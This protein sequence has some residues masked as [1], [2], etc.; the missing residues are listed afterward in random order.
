M[1][2]ENSYWVLRAESNELAVVHQC[3]RSG[4]CSF[5]ELVCSLVPR[6]ADMRREPLKD[7]YTTAG[8]KCQQTECDVVSAPNRTHRKCSRFWKHWSTK[9]NKYVLRTMPCETPRLTERG[10]LILP[11]GTVNVRSVT[12]A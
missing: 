6:D 1:T 9:I 11:T 10:T 2:G 7:Y 8:L 12:K 3:G 4:V 5:G